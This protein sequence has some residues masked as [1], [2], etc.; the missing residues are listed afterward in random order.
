[1]LAAALGW[2]VPGLHTWRIVPHVAVGVAASLVCQTT[3]VGSNPALALDQPQLNPWR[4]EGV[5][6]AGG[7]T[8]RWVN[9]FGHVAGTTGLGCTSS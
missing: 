1:M 2:R 9:H 8:W 6:Q 7:K 5:A 3:T 4:K